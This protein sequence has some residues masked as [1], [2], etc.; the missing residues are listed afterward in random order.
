MKELNDG[1]IRGVKMNNQKI[2]SQAAE[3]ARREGFGR[4]GTECGCKDGKCWE[5]APGWS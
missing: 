5:R 3:I 2:N 4:S 1:L